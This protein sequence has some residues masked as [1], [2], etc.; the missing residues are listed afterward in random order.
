MKP[1]PAI[2]ALAG[3]LTGSAA[4][5]VPVEESIATETLLSTPAATDTMNGATQTAVVATDTTADGLRLN[6]RG[7]SLDLVLDYFSDAAG[8]SIVLEAQP[9]GK[10]DVWC[11]QPLTKDEAVNLL[12]TVLNKNG[13]AAIRNGRTLKIV[14][15]EDAATHDIPV[16]YGGNPE[17]IPR[18]DEIVTQIIPARFV[19]AAQLLK[20]LQPLISAKTPMSANDTGNAIIITDT[21][22]NIR[23]VAEIVQAIDSSAEDVTVVRVFQLQYADPTELASQLTEVFASE[24]S[25]SGGQSPMQFGR[26]ARGGGL[27]GPGGMAGLGGGSSA[28]SSGSQNLRIQKRNRIVAVAEPRTA[29]VIV[30]ASREL[31]A[32]VESVVEELDANPAMQQKVH[33]VRPRNI[34]PQTALAVLKGIFQ[35][36]GT[37]SSLNSASQ[38]SPLDNRSNQQ[39]QSMTSTS[40]TGSNYRT[41]GTTRTATFGQ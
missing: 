36:S 30:T 12:N 34:D 17:N 6:F 40:A 26:G 13:L 5:S 7:A 41:G 8:F 21:Q 9:R 10:V 25:S 29:S 37:A 2:L 16:R 11:N 4:R 14:N 39:S 27:G 18:T 22:A 20:N 24:S 23:K 15:R 33:V 38:T 35:K 3:L 32:Q 1:I 28:S 19:E 31:M